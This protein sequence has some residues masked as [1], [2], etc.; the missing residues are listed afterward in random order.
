LLDEPLSALDAKVRLKLRRQIC[1]IQR[2]LKLT[3]IMVTHDQDEALTMADRIIVMN[4]AMIMQ[5]GT[6]QEI[7]DK[8]TS[9]FVADFIGSINFMDKEGAF[10][11]VRPENIRV[12]RNSEKNSV[13]AKLSEI[14][15]RG[16][17]CRLT[18]KTTHITD[19]TEFMI[20][21][22]YSELNNLK[23]TQGADIYINLPE[24]KLLRFA[25]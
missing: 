19:S 18:A 5:S 16:A 8:P 14:E 22:P 17:F 6:P 10:L 2:E 21:M 25:V 23:L 20:D 15:F 1:K 13:H 9:K 3:T 4:R 11:A 7:Y 12:S 24:E